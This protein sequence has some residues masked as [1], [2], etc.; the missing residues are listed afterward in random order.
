M[1]YATPVCMGHAH[2]H[3]HH[4]KHDHDHGH[5]DHGHDHGHHDHFSGKSTRTLIAALFIIGGFCAV[6]AVVGVVSGSLALLS[7]AGHMLSDVIALAIALVGTVMR[8]K[9]RGKRATFGHAR[10]AVLGGLI[11]GVLAVLVALFIIK[12]AAERVGAPPSV[13]GL[14]V[15]I[16]AALGL[17]INLGSAFMLHRSGDH[18]LGMRGAMLHMIGDALGSVAA[19]IAGVVLLSGGPTII[20]VVVSVVV[21]VVIAVGAVRL[22]RDAAR[23]LLEHAPAHLDTDALKATVRENARVSDVVALHAWS[24]DDGEGAASLVLATDELSVIALASAAD[25]LR[26]AIKAAYGVNH[27]VIEWRPTTSATACC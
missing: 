16:T 8:H 9:P 23:I 21:G 27:V 26:S 19:I 11:N 25:E 5:D 15:L 22:M 4:D 24:L 6:E 2:D 7:D 20:D 10:V 1:K 14:P 18:S 3:D 12:E 13:Q 17:A